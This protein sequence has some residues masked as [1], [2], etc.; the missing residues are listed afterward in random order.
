MDPYEVFRWLPRE[1]R[2]WYVKQMR[3]TLAVQR[4]DLDRAIRALAVAWLRRPR[5]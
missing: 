3:G 4:R 1:D 5:P 2:A